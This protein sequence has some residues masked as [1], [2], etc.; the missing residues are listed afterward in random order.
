MKIITYAT[1]NSQYFESLKESADKNNYELIVIG[2][3]TKWKGYRDKPLNIYN[4]LSSIDK[5]EFVIISDA[6]DV[7]ISRKS[8]EFMDEFNKYFLK[9]DIVFNAEAI[10]SYILLNEWFKNYKISKE[11]LSIK[12]KYKLFNSGVYVGK[13]KNIIS[14]L[15]KSLENGIQDDQK[16][17]IEIYNKS[18]NIKI[19]SDC[20]LFTTIS[21]YN[22]DVIVKNNKIYNKYSKSYPFFLHGPGPYTRLEPYMKDLNISN[23]FKKS[24]FKDYNYYYL[25]NYLD[26]IILF[27]ILLILFI[28]FKYVKK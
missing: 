19:D 14:F 26:F 23:N 18:S 5:D 16:S 7:I 2:F 20:K 12:S 28:I 15:E 25:T 17:F 9:D 22:N 6:F 8:C 4:Y 27:I 21:S 24:K 10:N 13:V 1:H 11:K 3:G